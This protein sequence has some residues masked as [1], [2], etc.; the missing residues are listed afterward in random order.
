MQ[1]HSKPTPAS[2]GECTPPSTRHQ[3]HW[4]A[5]T[6]CSWAAGAPQAPLAVPGLADLLQA[7]V[8]PRLH[9]ADVQ[10]LGQ[11][12][13]AARALVQGLPN[14]VLSSLIQAGTCLRAA[15]SW[16]SSTDA[17]QAAMQAQQLQAHAGCKPREQLDRWASWAAAVRQGRLQLDQELTHMQAGNSR[18][19]NLSPSADQVAAAGADGS[20]LL[21]P[22]PRGMAHVDLSAL[23]SACAQALPVSGTEPGEPALRAVRFQW[24]PLGQALVVFSAGSSRDRLWRTSTYRGL[25]LLGSWV[26]VAP[27]QQHPCHSHLHVAAGA[28]QFWV[29]MAEGSSSTVLACT[30]QGVTARHTVPVAAHAWAPSYDGCCLLTVSPAADSLFMCTGGPGA[31]S[32]ALGS[33]LPGASLSG[34]GCWGSLAVS[35]HHTAAADRLCWLDLQRGCLL[36]SEH[37]AP[38][39]GGAPVLGRRSAALSCQDGTVRVLAVTGAGTGQQLFV[40]GGRFPCFDPVLGLYLALGLSSGGVAVLHGTTGA[41][42]ATWKPC[43]SHCAWPQPAWLPDAS[44]LVVQSG[45]WSV[46]RFAGS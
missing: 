40:C 12:C 26:E 1:E 20:V 42:L 25:R 9:L 32:C 5:L 37:L 36:H 21:A 17:E 13:A 31:Q 45:M 15:L 34:T 30:P 39:T 16:L 4:P 38:A 46:L 33:Q 35:Q 2:S 43:V 28:A 18:A 44:G 23:L 14:A 6:S 27:P 8:V 10:S 41:T 29:V 24:C 3:A 11:A 7:H 19:C 22:I